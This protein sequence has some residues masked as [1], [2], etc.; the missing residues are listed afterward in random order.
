MKIVHTMRSQQ[1]NF[2]P[3]SEKSVR[4]VGDRYEPTCDR[5]HLRSAALRLIVAAVTLIDQSCECLRLN[6]TGVE[7]KS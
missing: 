1:D 5:L 2:D 7:P 4:I 6:R 3:F